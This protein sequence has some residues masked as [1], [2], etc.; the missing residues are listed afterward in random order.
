MN[1]LNIIGSISIKPDWANI[2]GETLKAGTPLS[3]TGVVANNGN[4]LGLLAQ[5]A[6]KGDTEVN[7]VYAGLVDIGEVET[8]Y[9]DSLADDCKAA[10]KGITFISA[11]GEAGVPSGLPDSSEASQGDVLTIGSS[12]PEWDA[13]SGGGGTIWYYSSAEYEN[14]Q[15]LN[16]DPVPSATL[17]ADVEAGKDVRIRSGLIT[18]F[19]IGVADDV[20]LVSATSTLTYDED[21]GYTLTVGKGNIDVSSTNALSVLSTRSVTISAS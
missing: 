14:L 1:F 20:V 3:V 18:Y 5:E 17:I 15:D 13:P 10:L 21:Y 12:G 19:A 9:G 11:S 16:G 2:S 4:A 8:S 6:H 7:V